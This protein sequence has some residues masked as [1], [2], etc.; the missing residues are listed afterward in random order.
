MVRPIE[1]TPLLDDEEW[2][3]LLNEMKDVKPKPLKFHKVNHE[4]IKAIMEEV[5]KKRR[6]VNVK[7]RRAIL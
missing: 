3:V 1:P 5:A 6:V 2:A 4:E 7:S